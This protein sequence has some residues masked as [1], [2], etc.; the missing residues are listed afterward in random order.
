MNLNTTRNHLSSDSVAD[1]LVRFLCDNESELSLNDAQLYY[2]FPVFKDIDGEI[3]ISKILLVSPRH[4][5]LVIEKSGAINCSDFLSEIE[6]I[7][8]NAEQVFSSLYSRIIRNK[9]LKKSK[10][11][12][13]FSLEAI[14]YAPL[15]ENPPINLNIE[16]PVLFTQ[17]KLYEYIKEL[18]ADSI[19]GTSFSELVSTIEGS[20][21]I[22]RPKFRDTTDL[23]SDSKGFFVKSLES[24]IASF[25]QNQKNG[26]T[27][28]T[29][30]LQRIRGLAGSGKTIV[31]AMK[32]AI[33]HLRDPN[34]I[35]I[36]T[37]YTKSLYQYIQRLITRFYRQF[38]DKDP[39]WSR[40]RIMHAWGGKQNPGVY[41]DICQTHGIEPISYTKASGLSG[42]G[43]S[44]DFVC[45]NLLKNPDLKK[46]YDYLFI[47]EGQDFP[48]SF[49]KL[50]V[51]LTNKNRVV[52]AYDELQ[53]IFQTKI[54]TSEEIFGTDKNGK[55][56][57]EFS[58]DIVLY[59]CY[60]NPREILVT[61]HALGFGIY[62]SRIVQMLENKEHWEDIG[63]KVKEGEF[64]EGSSV[65]IERPEENSLMKISNSYNKDEIVQNFVF[66]SF[67][68]EIDFVTDRIERDI[69]EDRLL[70][71]DILVIVVDDRNAKH[72]LNNLEKKLAEKE[73]RSN[74]IHADPYSLRDFQKEDQVT[75]STV[76]K[77][78]GNEAFMV[79]IMGVD[80]LF[81][82]YAGVHE[83]NVLFTAITRAKG[84]IRI[85]GIGASSA[86]CK[87]EIKTAL[88]T[89]PY[90]T[91][92]YPS[93]EQLKI[94]SRDL[95]EKAIK[96]RN[97][98]RM[99][100]R[101]LEDMSPTEI[102]R[103]IKQRS[104]KKGQD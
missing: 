96:K 66:N 9:I 13:K 73:I 20:K 7:D 10:R 59:K 79:Y 30:G 22:I 85:S 72:Y 4:G 38:D 99:L 100:D 36:Y 91:F 44:F 63:Y 40:I 101:A 75:L 84:W 89:M 12:L 31:L 67:S 62:S 71:D 42:D 56:L 8:S 86:L 58:E 24:E 103:F 76:H 50:C 1:G 16:T 94:M 104:I 2:D 11:E 49:L 47:D 55:P 90:L 54:P 87:E 69:K 21:G 82:S 26:Y 70:P 51:K 28:P 53:T 46:Q 3:I 68:E 37:F 27:V 39:D 43:D 80:V 19:E 23:P 18:E 95:Q 77:A 102:I 45:K 29:E 65:T 88:E 48:L 25:D 98:E 74:N 61:A 33:T 60:R 34:A 15:V 32:A 81:S 57:V 92:V 6:R 64:S 5:V 93:E 41:F 14:I 17:N 97:T 52:W 78:K 83:R 35:I